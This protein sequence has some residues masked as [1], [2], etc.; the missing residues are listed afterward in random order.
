MS[1]KASVDE[2]CRLV[3]QSLQ[4]GNPV[5]NSRDLP[6]VAD[7][8]A[9]HDQ[10]EHQIERTVDEIRPCENNHP[11]HAWLALLEGWEA[12]RTADGQDRRESGRQPC[13]A[14]GLRAGTLPGLQRRGCEP[15]LHQRCCAL[16]NAAIRCCG[17][18]SRYGRVDAIVWLASECSA[19]KNEMI[20]KIS[21]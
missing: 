3:A 13:R 7:A 4:V 16:S 17:F 21:I 2:R 6:G 9:F 10:F 19:P 5:N 15:P 14:S 12:S 18:T 1:Y 8:R 11:R 20:N